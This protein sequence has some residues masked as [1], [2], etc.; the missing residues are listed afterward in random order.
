MWYCPFS[1]N[2]AKCLSRV[3]LRNLQF[4][5]RFWS[6]VSMWP[7]ACDFYGLWTNN[8]WA[9]GYFP[10]LQIEVFSFVFSVFF[11]HLCLNIFIIIFIF[12]S[13]LS[14]TCQT[15]SAHVRASFAFLCDTNVCVWDDCPPRKSFKILQSCSHSREDNCSPLYRVDI[16]RISAKSFLFKFCSC[17]FCFCLAASSPHPTSYS[18]AVYGH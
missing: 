15:F 9:Q 12:I 17:R 13:P 16:F 2:P 14:K 10:P 3:F 8:R 4:R 6:C 7:C 18:Q 1:L 5:A 11:I